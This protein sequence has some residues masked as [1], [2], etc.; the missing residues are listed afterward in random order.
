MGLATQRHLNVY[1]KTTETCN[2]NCSHCFTSGIN[3]AKIYFY[4]VKTAAWVNQIYRDTIFYE[5]HGGEPM[6]A[7]VSSLRKFVELTQGDGVMYGTTTNLVYKLT[8]ER[9][10]FFDD[11]L[12]KR[13]GTS[14]DPTI[15]F[16]NE[17]QR[18]L[19]ED[20]VLSLIHI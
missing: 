3:G 10:Q 20:N 4:P 12:E 19:W 7:S 5:F 6:L 15:R 9:L 18:K 11:V 16:S 1:I 17:K 2:L 14:W 8:E 13:I